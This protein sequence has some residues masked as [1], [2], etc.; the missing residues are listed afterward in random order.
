MRYPTGFLIAVHTL[1]Q[2]PL[3]RME[4]IIFILKIPTGLLRHGKS[5]MGPKSKS[6]NRPRQDGPS[7]AL[8]VPQTYRLQAPPLSHLPPPSGIG[9]SRGP[10]VSFTAQDM[11]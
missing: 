9:R 6:D 10:R 2:A 1:G 11:R 5:G 4:G 7:L 8:V 3:R